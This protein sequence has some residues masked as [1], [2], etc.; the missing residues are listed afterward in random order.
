[1]SGG[2]VHT[3]GIG[4]ANEKVRLVSRRWHE[5]RANVVEAKMAGFVGEV[6]WAGGCAGSER[7]D[8]RWRPWSRCLT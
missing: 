2:A 1:V 7:D 8:V 4:N 5:A 6:R 3:T